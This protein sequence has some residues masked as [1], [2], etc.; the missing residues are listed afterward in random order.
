MSSVTFFYPKWSQRA[1]TQTLQ[2]GVKRLDHLLPL[3]RAVL[4]GSW[5]RDRATVASDIDVLIV[6]CGETRDDAYGLVWRTLALPGLELHLYSETE[7][8][9][10]KEMLARMSVGGI[11]LL[12]EAATTL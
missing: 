4:F 10:L 3:E 9:Q 12:P 8:A 5:S 2:A 11:S 6:Y 1:L 7:A